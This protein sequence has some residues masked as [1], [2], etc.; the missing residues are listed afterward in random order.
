MSD[1]IE[2][3]TFIKECIIPLYQLDNLQVMVLGKRRQLS[4]A[5]KSQG[6][7]VP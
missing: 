4:G 6:E 7:K 3:P 2:L 1:L 5:T